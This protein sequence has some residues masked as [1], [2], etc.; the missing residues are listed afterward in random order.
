MAA[1]STG[2]RGRPRHP[3]ISFPPIFGILI[4]IAKFGLVPAGKTG[5][6]S[7]GERRQKVSPSA[8]FVCRFAAR[9]PD[10]CIYRGMLFT[11]VT[12]RPRTKRD[13]QFM[14]VSKLSTTYSRVRAVKRFLLYID[15][16]EIAVRR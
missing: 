5:C 15:D 4:L 14:R 8:G 6:W 12:L 11:I 10:K 3:V 16:G 2:S 9:R 13:P 7:D 1:R